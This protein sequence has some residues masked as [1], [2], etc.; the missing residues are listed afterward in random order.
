M[1]ML[2]PEDYENDAPRIR[3]LKLLPAWPIRLATLV[4][5]LIG[6]AVAVDAYADEPQPK[7]IP[8]HVHEE[9]GLSVRLMPGPCVEPI[10]KASIRPIHRERAKAIESDW[11]MADGSVQPFA[12]CWIELSKEE[13]KTAKDVFVLFFSDGEIYTVFTSAFGAKPEGS[14]GI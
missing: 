1:T 9:D 12:G 7:L 2:Y 10:S 6:V 14:V 4:A 3:G 5:L 13:A 8:L 11:R